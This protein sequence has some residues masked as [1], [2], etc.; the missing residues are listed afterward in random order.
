MNNH[1]RVTIRNISLSLA[2]ILLFGGFVHKPFPL[3]LLAIGGFAGAAL[4]IGYSIRNMTVP[5]AFGMD[6]LNRKILLYIIPSILLGFILG[7]LTRNRFELPLLPSGFTRV[8]LLAPLIGAAEELLFR[9]YMQGQARPL[10]RSFSVLYASTGHTIYKLL[11]IM[12]L[13]APLQFEPLFLAAW[14]FIGGVLF[15]IMRELSEST[16]PPVIAHAL[17]DIML[18]GGLASAPLWVWS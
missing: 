2:G 17:F 11:V 18:Y 3:L 10:G 16:I 9:G 14:T 6:R 15:G 1:H 13:S 8:A 7:I 5:G 4:M 12:T